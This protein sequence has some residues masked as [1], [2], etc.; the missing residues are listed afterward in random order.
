MG[1]FVVLAVRSFVKNCGMEEYSIKQL[2]YLA[3]LAT[4]KGKQEF[5][6]ELCHFI[7]DDFLYELRKLLHF[8]IKNEAIVVNKF[9]VIPPLFI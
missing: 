1:Y 8:R 4:T 6:M 3:M 5:L 2:W 9:T 7:G